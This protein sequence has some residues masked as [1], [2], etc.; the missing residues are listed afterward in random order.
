MLNDKKDSVK[1]WMLRQLQC[2][3]ET[4]DDCGEVNCT[5]LGEN[6][7]QE[8][9]LYESDGETI[10]ELVFDWAVEVEWALLDLI[11]DEKDKDP[12]ELN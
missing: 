7:A 8:F 6:A 12:D 5:L 4:Y 9:L 10:P 2:D 11:Q 1:A 3:R